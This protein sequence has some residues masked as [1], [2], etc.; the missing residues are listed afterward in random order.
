MNQ[1]S[2]LTTLA[3]LLFM[4][5]GVG[6]AWAGTVTF[7]F[8]SDEG[9]EALRILKPTS[10]NGTDLGTTAYTLDG[11]SLTAD[12]GSSTNTRVWNSN[13]SLEL[14][15]YSG[16]SLTFTA[17][18]PNAITKIEL[19]GS[20]TKPFSDEDK[21]FD[22]NTSTWTGNATSVTLT[23][24]GTAKISTITVTYGED[25]PTPGVIDFE[26]PA[27]TYTYWKFSNMQSQQSGNSNITAHGGSYYGTTGGKATASI[28]T[29]AKV[30]RPKTLT[31][32]VSKQSN[33]TNSSTW[34]IQVSTDRNE[35]K[36]VEEKDATSMSAGVWEEFT[37]DLLAYSDVYVRVYYEGSTAIRNID[38][39]TLDM[40]DPTAPLINATDPDEL[41]CNATSGSITYTIDN[42]AEGTMSATTNADWISGFTYSQTNE[43]GQV[44]FITTANTS[45]SR[46]GTVTLV[47][48]YGDN[49]TVKKEVTITQAEY[50]TTYTLATSVEPGKHYIIVGKKNGTYKAMG[51]QD[52]NNRNAIDVDD[53]NNTISV[54]VTDVVREFAIYGSD[55]NYYAIYDETQRGYLYAASDTK[56]WLRTQSINNEDSKWSI[57][58]DSDT[59][60]ASIIADKSSNR[61]EM[62]Y[63]SSATCFSCYGA[64]N[65]QEP[66]YLYVRV[67]EEAPAEE[68]VTITDVKYATYCSAK[69]LDFS[70][71]QGVKVYK[72]KAN[73]NDVTLTAIT[74]GIVPPNTG[75]IIYKDV[76]AATTV[77][78]AVSTTLGAGD[79]TDNELIGTLERTIVYFEGEEK[80]NYILQSDGQG[81]VVF[82]KARPIDEGFYYMP[83]NRAYLST[84][85]TY[86]GSRLAVIT[87]DDA[88]GIRNV[89]RA[90]HDN[91]TWYDLQGRSVKIPAK[92]L[93]IVNGKKRIV[94]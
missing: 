69:A 60:E 39:L 78:V 11:V 66:V 20:T 70:G 6:T 59:N 72:A 33:N 29:Q 71:E 37:A 61:N 74:D 81:S 53:S 64:G 55:D 8:N 42:Y 13:G 3:L 77:T 10:G 34:Y 22:S 30:A 32:Y 89:I 62:R 57:S 23:A 56:N 44:N 48:T 47:Y 38:D 58:I 65:S 90:A 73:T 5:A 41:A 2:L 25:S 93:Y 88:A 15:V 16:G 31:C 52:D 40:V 91:D 83:A 94:K 75:V 7:T 67:D 68:H 21:G 43:N 86:S 35:W 79:W 76:D 17:P 54:K 92:G 63:N 26:S 84:T 51:A 36:T 18:A 46:S 50:A 28:T 14:R 24:T 45:Y 4:I 85:S 19:T 87:P 1:K 9:L 80:Y 82:N 49:N 12:H 27:S